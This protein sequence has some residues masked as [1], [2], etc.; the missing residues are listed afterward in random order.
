MLQLS[1]DPTVSFEV[2][3]ASGATIKTKG[4]CSNIKVFMQGHNFLVDLNALPLGDY[5]LVL[6]TQW[7]RTLGMI[8]W[9]FLAMS[10]QFQHL[11]TFVT[12]FGMH[13][14]D[15]TLQDGDHFFK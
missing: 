12:L 14:T 11:L 6:G 2:K 7:L 13:S 8:Q 4:V 3:V 9:D 5:E 1:V 10:M 15:L